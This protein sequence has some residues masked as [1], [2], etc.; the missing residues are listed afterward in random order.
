MR[1]GKAEPTP[2]E[3]ADQKHYGKEFIYY[4]KG[5]EGWAEPRGM[6]R[7]RPG[8][9]GGGPKIRCPPSPPRT[10][11]EECSYTKRTRGVKRRKGSKKG[12]SRRLLRKE[13]VKVRAAPI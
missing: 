6:P 2:N 9:H 7:K 4:E 12:G 11:E 10:A 1:P 8:I 13:K 3:H 5:R